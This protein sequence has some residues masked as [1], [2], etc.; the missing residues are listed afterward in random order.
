MKFLYYLSAI[1]ESNLDI[2]L[3]I[4]KN[5]LIYIYE[6]IKENFDIMINCYDDTIK[7]QELIDSFEFIKQKFIHKKK[8]RLVQLW[9]TNPYH[10]LIDNYD[11]ILYIMDDIEI[12]NLDINEM[13]KIKET[14]N[15]S[16][17]SPK[18]IG[19]TWDY[20]KNQDDNVLAFSNRVEIYC[21][22][23]NKQDFFKFIEINDIENTHTW[24][25]DFMLGYYKI[26]SAIYYKFVV[27]H[28]LPTTTI[29]NNAM[30]EMNIYL[31]KRGFSNL[32]QITRKYPDFINKITF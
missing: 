24:G 11:Y 7:V 6:N 5:N 10:K 1:G 20:M 26:K 28:K 3:N 30:K 23:F 4:L 15:I 17:L 13:I 29:R 32:E 16:F 14:Y 21:L 31:R 18:V 27:S 12:N 8:G 22:I 2:K 25:V 19:S 9:K